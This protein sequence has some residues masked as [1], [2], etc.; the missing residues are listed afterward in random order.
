VY[1]RP[2]DRPGGTQAVSGEGGST[3]VWARDGRALFFIEGQSMMEARVTLSPFAIRKP[4]AL[5]PL[6]APATAFDVAPDGRFLIVLTR[7]ASVADELRIVL[8]WSRNPL[9]R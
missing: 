7:A 4:A 9:P 3:P 5:F 2:F 8:G 1:V 6:P